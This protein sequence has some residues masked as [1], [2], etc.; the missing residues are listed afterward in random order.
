VQRAGLET[1]FVVR[2]LQIQQPRIL[3]NLFY[4]S[5]HKK[6][7]KLKKQPPLTPMD[8]AIGIE[9]VVIVIE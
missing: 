5:K 8:K 3:A 2:A 4:Q 1:G 7:E 6:Q 9:G